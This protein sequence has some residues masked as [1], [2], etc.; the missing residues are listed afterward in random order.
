MKFLAAVLLIGL[1][2]AAVPAS[3]APLD[4]CRSCPPPKTYDSQRV[5]RHTKT[6]DRSRVINTHSVV[7]RPP[8]VRVIAARPPVTVV[9]MVVRKYRIIHGP[10][11]DA[12]TDV[13]YPVQP[14]CKH[15]VTRS[16]SCILRVGG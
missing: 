3:A 8:S 11:P 16:G 13:V 7:Y 9:N 5:I 15:G 6:V 12:M 4:G 10:H 1:A 14:R 2:L